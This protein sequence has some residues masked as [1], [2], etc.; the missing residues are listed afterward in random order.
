MWQGISSYKSCSL[1]SCGHN[2][3]TVSGDCATF[4]RQQ[5]AMFSP[6][7]EV[8]RLTE[9]RSV[10]LVFIFLSVRSRAPFIS[11]VWLLLL[12]NTAPLT[13]HNTLYR[14]IHIHQQLEKIC[15]CIVTFKA[16]TN[17]IL[18]LHSP[19]MINNK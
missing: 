1:H 9:G 12:Q 8:D 18:F 13:A 4:R 10:W 5:P 16:I 11:T 14:I 3:T 17:V 7:V 15:H 19:L 6:S 2:D